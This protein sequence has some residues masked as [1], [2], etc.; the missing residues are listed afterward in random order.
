MV[1]VGIAWGSILAM[2]YAILSGAL[3]PKK[4]G[5]YMGIFNF[6]IT[7]PQIVNGL[8][9]GMIVKRLYKGEAIFAIVIAGVFMLIA[10]VSVLYVRDR[11]DA[12]EADE[13]EKAAVAISE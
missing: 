10:A 13:P 11:H 5:V 9:G 3:P 8:F 7:F 4:M 1:G 6:F 12:L 2:P